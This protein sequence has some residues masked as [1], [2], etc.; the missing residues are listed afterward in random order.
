[1]LAYPE[2]L[3]QDLVGL[4]VTRSNHAHLCSESAKL[5]LLLPHLPL[6]DF[7]ATLFHCHVLCDKT[8]VIRSGLLLVKR[9]I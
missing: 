2:V 7:Q 8:E 5:R 4:P 3:S 1:M 9:Y 6:H